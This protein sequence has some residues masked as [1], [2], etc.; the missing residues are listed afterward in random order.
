MK[1]KTLIRFTDLKENT[2][3]EVGEQFE[4]TK[5]RLEEILLV[6]SSPLVEIVEEKPKEV[7]KKAKK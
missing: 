1:V 5:E 6:L 4:V 7:K 3:R 2:I